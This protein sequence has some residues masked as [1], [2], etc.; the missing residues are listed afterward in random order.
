M[1]LDRYGSYIDLSATERQGIDYSIVSVDRGSSVT[2]IAPHGGQIEPPTSALALA[3]A[4]DDYNAYCFDGLCTGREHHEL[5][6]TSNNFDEPLGCALIAKSDIVV[7]LHGR[8]D[9]KAPKS[10][11]IGGLDGEL[12]DRIASHLERAGFQVATAGHEFPALDLANIC[13]RG[14]RKKGVQIEI[15]RTLR[16]VLSRDIRVFNQFANAA[17]LSIADAVRA[18]TADTIARTVPRTLTHKA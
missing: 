5:H 1:A 13:N 12:C 10:V 2:I 18:E 11:W 3:I 7:A 15:P 14:R 9:R 8:R 6:I 17:R 4:H 16:D